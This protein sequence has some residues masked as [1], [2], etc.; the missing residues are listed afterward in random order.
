MEFGKET[1]IEKFRQQ[2]V[3]NQML[4]VLLI[5]LGAGGY[6]WYGDYSKAQQAKAN[7]AHQVDPN[8]Q[9]QQNLV[10]ELAKVG[11]TASVAM[12]MWW[13]GIR[14]VPLV[15][16]GWQLSAVSCTNG[17][18][19]QVQWSMIDGW[20]G[21]ANGIAD[22]ALKNPVT[23]STDGRSAAYGIESKTP[24]EK[25][26]LDGSGIQQDIMIKTKSMELAARIRAG[27]GEFQ[28]Q[29]ATIFALPG[30]V[31]E[32]QVSNPVKSGEWSFSGKAWM[33]DLL[34]TAI[35]DAFRV[36]GLELSVMNGEPNLKIKGRYY[37]R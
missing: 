32:A 12:S 28:Y 23:Y 16:Q 27:G 21:P 35:P 19:C 24:A 37:V 11:P 13:D 20:V 2:I 9:Y 10:V 34:K 22:L 33:F 31:T 14:A 15:V 5:G 17:T 6:L 26:P 30:G 7:Q 36:E 4:A 25:T 3:S 1:H 29:P 18:P 8:T